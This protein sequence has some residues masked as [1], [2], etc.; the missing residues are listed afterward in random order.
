MFEDCG[1]LML[2]HGVFRCTLS[3]LYNLADFEIFEH[4]FKSSI[5]SRYRIM[6]VRAYMWIGLCSPAMKFTGTVRVHVCLLN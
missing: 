6:L 4:T 5:Y 1:S 3:S 2:M